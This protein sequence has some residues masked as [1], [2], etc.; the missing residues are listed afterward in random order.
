VVNIIYQLQ[1]G[2]ALRNGGIKLRFV[3]LDTWKI[4]PSLLGAEYPLE[5]RWPLA[6]PKAEKEMV[7]K[8]DA[9][10]FN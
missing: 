7:F 4:P 5:A 1:N 2:L 3:Q 10:I 8:V 6:R 9:K